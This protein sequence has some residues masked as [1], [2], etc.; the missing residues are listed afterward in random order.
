MAL[1]A[2][3]LYYLRADQLRDECA[4]RGLISSGPVHL[5]RRRLR[6]FLRSAEMGGVSL[7]G[8][9]QISA[10]V[11]VMNLNSSVCSKL[12]LG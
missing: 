8:G 7:P 4:V 11:D 3:S 1:S 2:T 6:E 9:E 10:P 12:S 5:L